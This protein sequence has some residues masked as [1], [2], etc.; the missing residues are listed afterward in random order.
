LDGNSLDPSERGFSPAA[1]SCRPAL[2]AS[3]PGSRATQVTGVVTSNDD[4]RGE[5]DGT[6]R[7]LRLHPRLLVADTNVPVRH[8]RPVRRAS[9]HQRQP[10]SR[11]G[12]LRINTSEFPMTADSLAGDAASNDGSRR[13]PQLTQAQQ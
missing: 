3:K 1:S 6:R 13:W 9:A 7:A 12:E 8:D 10:G 11:Y 2:E 5:G 4:R